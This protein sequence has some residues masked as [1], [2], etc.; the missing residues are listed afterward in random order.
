V[1]RV[2]D[3]MGTVINAHERAVE[4]KESM[5]DIHDEEPIGRY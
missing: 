4:L 2:Y 1:I 3:E 5:T